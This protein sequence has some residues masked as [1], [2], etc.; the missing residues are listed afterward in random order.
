MVLVLVVH[1]HV[2][3]DDPSGQEPDLAGAHLADID[4]PLVRM[5]SS[6]PPRFHLDVS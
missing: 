6:Y 4:A 3:F 2:Q 5:H 1:G